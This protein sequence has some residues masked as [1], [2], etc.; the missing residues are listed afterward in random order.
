[1][2]SLPRFMIDED[3]DPTE[4]KDDAEAEDEDGVSMYRIGD[5]FEKDEA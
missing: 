5:E 2:R 4:E 1:M 3:E